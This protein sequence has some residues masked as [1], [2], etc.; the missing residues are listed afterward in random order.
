MKEL[1]ESYWDNRYKTHNT[2]WDLGEISPPLKSYIDQLVDKSIRILI[3]G[4]GNSYEAEYLF[5]QGFKNVFVVDVSITAL[6]N[7]AMRVPDFPKQQ[8]IHSNFFDLEMTFDLILE[9]TFF[10]ALH[11]NLRSDYALKMNS[12]LSENGKLIGLLFNVPLNE[13]HPPF[14]GHRD[15]Y[16]KYFETIFHI[17]IMDTCYNS[18]FSRTGRELFIK[19]LKTSS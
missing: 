15:E 17:D 3:P 6:D 13:D 5:N 1:D 14:G 11:P 2:G 18:I 16:I 19:L 4:G 12:L 9:Q 7:I 8:L 10:C